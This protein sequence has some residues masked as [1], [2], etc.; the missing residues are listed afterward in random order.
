MQN[1]WI[2]KECAPGV[3]NEKLLEAV[4]TAYSIENHAGHDVEDLSAN[5]IGTVYAA[6]QPDALFLLYEGSGYWYES[7]RVTPGGTVNL[8]ESVF[9]HPEKATEHRRR[10]RK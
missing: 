1:D 10:K 6:G 3:A 4:K 8:Y 5:Y 7:M 9:G 2:V